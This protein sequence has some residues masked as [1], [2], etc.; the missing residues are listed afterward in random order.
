M[1]YSYL[2]TVVLLILVNLSIA[3]QNTIRKVKTKSRAKK[4]QKQLQE[5]L[6][7]QKEEMQKKIK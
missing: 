1:G 6:K 5:R 7:V 3:V 4:M 2:A